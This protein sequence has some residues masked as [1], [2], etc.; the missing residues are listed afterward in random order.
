MPAKGGDRVGYGQPPRATRFKPGQSGNPKGRPKGSK[1]FSADLTA[2][3]NDR[4]S[5]NEN[6][7]RKTITKRA[8]ITKQ[9]VNRAASGDLKAMPLLLRE[10]RAYEI[11]AAPLETDGRA[12]PEDRAVM[13]GILA[14]LRAADA[15]RRASAETGAALE[16]QAPSCPAPSEGEL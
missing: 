2:E 5:V 8:A 13:E 14:R 6:G 4:V 1:S 9:L 15:E 7:K 16:A 3:L 11:D 12:G 10:A